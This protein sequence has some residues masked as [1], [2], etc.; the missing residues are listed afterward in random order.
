MWE[1]K[2]NCTIESTHFRVGWR[3]WIIISRNFI[4]FDKKEGEQRKIQYSIENRP[5]L[6]WPA[7]LWHSSPFRALLASKLILI[8][9]QL[10]VLYVGVVEFKSTRA[11]FLFNFQFHFGRN[12]FYLSLATRL[13]VWRLKYCV[14]SISANQKWFQIDDYNF[15]LRLFFLLS[16]IFN[17]SCG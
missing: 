4:W 3:C 9:L 2:L 1:M 17:V 16:L 10:L 13:N 5:F 7:R 14:D 6:A 11:L 12:V 8:Y 15:F